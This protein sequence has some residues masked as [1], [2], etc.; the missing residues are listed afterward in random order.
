MISLARIAP[1]LAV[2]AA[3]VVVVIAPSVA[4]VQ[5]R[6]TSSPFG[7]APQ[8]SKHR[9]PDVVPESSAA[10]GRATQQKLNPA[11]TGGAEGLHPN[12]LYP[13]PTSKHSGTPSPDAFGAVPPPSPVPAF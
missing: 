8:P 10:A 12:R 11:A 1:S 7:A 13:A 5:N 4:L 9:R 6:T 3:D 2:N